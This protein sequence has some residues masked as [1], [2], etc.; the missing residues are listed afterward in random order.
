M[1]LL[2]LRILIKMKKMIL[3]YP[4]DQQ[5]HGHIIQYTPKGVY[6][7][8]L[9]KGQYILILSL[10]RISGSHQLWR[11]LLGNLWCLGVKIPDLGNLLLQGR[12]CS[13]YIDP[14]DQVGNARIQFILIQG[15]LIDPSL[16]MYQEIHPFVQLGM[17]VLKVLFP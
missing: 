5:G 16:G 7:E 6:W 15:N 8:M 2:Q 3:V 12:C 1:L 14:L 4:E 9:P 13:Q 11:F 10:G 17:T